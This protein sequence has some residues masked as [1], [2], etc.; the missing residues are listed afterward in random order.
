MLEPSKALISWAFRCTVSPYTQDLPLMLLVF[1]DSELFHRVI[2]SMTSLS[3]GICSTFCLA[4][5]MEVAASLRWTRQQK[6]CV[7]PSKRLTQFTHKTAWASTSSSLKQPI[8]ARLSTSAIFCPVCD[9]KRR[10]I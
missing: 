6:S 4:A 7:L 1:Q 10:H 9:S 3:G 8:S 2:T 5:N